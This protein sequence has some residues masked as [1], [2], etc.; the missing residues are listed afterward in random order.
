MLFRITTL[1]P[2]Y[3]CIAAPIIQNL[4]NK[5]DLFIGRKEAIEDIRK[6]IEK[7]AWITI[8]GSTGIGKTQLSKSFV[9]ENQDKY[10]L[11]WWF[12]A[13]QNISK[14]FLSL[15]EALNKD[16]SNLKIDQLSGDELIKTV[17]EEIKKK[18]KKAFFVFDN[19]ISHDGVKE[20]IEKI[21]KYNVNGIVTSKSNFGWENIFNLKSFSSEESVNFLIKTTS[22]KD[23]DKAKKLSDKL[24]NYPLALATGAN[25]MKNNPGIDYEKYI[26]MILED[27]SDND[28]KKIDI[29]DLVDESKKGIF[30]TIML[31]I[32]DIKKKDPIAYDLAIFI[33]HLDTHRIPY[34]ILEE[35]CKKASQKE[36]LSKEK[37]E[38]TIKSLENITFIHKDHDRESDIFYSMHEMIGHVVRNGINAQD[39]K[40]SVTIG[41]E[42]MYSLLN[43]TRLDY[44]L[45][46]MIKNPWLIYH[47]DRFFNYARSIKDIDVS[48]LLLDIYVKVIEYYLS[49]LRDVHKVREM[50]FVLEKDI[51]KALPATRGVFWINKGNATAWENPD[52]PEAIKFMTEG[53][54]ILKTLKD[55]NE[56]KMRACSNLAQFHL[57]VGDYKEAE[58][59]LKEGD[60]YLDSSQKGV[61][62]SLFHYAKSLL[63]TELGNH[64]EAIT[65]C[66]KALELIEQYKYHGLECAIHGFKG[67]NY[68]SLGDYK[69]CLKETDI[70]LSI[71]EEH[72]QSGV[73]F[74]WK[75]IIKSIQGF[76]YCV[77]KDH[78]KADSALK[79]AIEGFD[80][81]YQGSSKNIRQAHTMGFQGYS[82]VLKKDYAKA[83]EYFQKSLSLY[84]SI[85]KELK[86]FL[87]KKFTVYAALSAIKIKDSK[88]YESLVKS[89]EESFGKDDNLDFL[90]N[91]KNGK[92]ITNKQ[93][94][95]YS[96][97]EF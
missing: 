76:G 36:D 52:Y 38:N 49:G 78:E 26:K 93:K 53:L 47:A 28:T 46:E 45:L 89:Y 61:Y 41:T 65:T 64:K 95:E 19:A 23:K 73:N 24:G 70:S 20:T 6:K 80:I 21:K 1:I 84:R 90:N 67:I 88:T 2:I 12:D 62:E 58:K 17:L 50:I 8:T 10:D 75:A 9:H 13:S 69:A 39:I 35:F 42:V 54:N 91:T 33:S 56:E 92:E 31:N 40:K 86:H 7:D 4:P 27:S 30:A 44:M 14:Q 25:Y 11:I 82:C 79:E 81:I 66:D 72:M 74:A 63:M 43:K 18:N 32:R 68:A 85:C 83:I 3:S 34:S 57:A 5:N 51:D 59:I 22:I 55:K 71:Y 60:E 94:E 96:F 29:S 16:G 48:P 97:F 77:A 37:I 87:A 15:G